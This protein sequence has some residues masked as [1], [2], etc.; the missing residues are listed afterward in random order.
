MTQSTF[1]ESH[2]RTPVDQA[3]TLKPASVRDEEE[4]V[5]DEASA[6]FNEDFERAASGVSRQFALNYD[7]VRAAYAGR[8]QSLTV[9]FKEV[10]EARKD[11]NSYVG[12]SVFWGIFFWPVALYTGYKA[13]DAFSKLSALKQQVKGTVDS[14]KAAQA[15]KAPSA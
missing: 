8:K 12:W 11:R 9:A 14:Y 7:D 13:Y 1:E 5:R 2:K 6:K 3:M 4:R 15:P 10:S